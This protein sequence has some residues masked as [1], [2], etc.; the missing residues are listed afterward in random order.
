[1]LRVLLILALLLACA[2]PSRP[3]SGAGAPH[4]SGLDGGAAGMGALGAAVQAG[5]RDCPP[6]GSPGREISVPSAPGALSCAP[7]GSGPATGYPPAPPPR[8]DDGTHPPPP[9]E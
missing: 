1:M 3:Q 7:T 9:G 2:D 6:R 8:R 5:N 4:P